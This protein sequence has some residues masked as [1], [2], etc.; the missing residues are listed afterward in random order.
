MSKQFPHQYA[1]VKPTH[2]SADYEKDAL[3]ALDATGACR[4]EDRPALLA[5]A[6]VLATLAMA[7]AVV[8]AA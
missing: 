1:R 4:A 8:E 6:Q 7:R 2:S 5:A 3:E